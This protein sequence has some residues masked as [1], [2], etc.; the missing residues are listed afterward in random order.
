[1]YSYTIIQW[2]FFFYFYCFFGWCFESTFVSIRKK[3]L[4][5]R[6][7]MR[8]PF[9]PIYGTGAIMMLVVSMPFQGNIFLVYIAGC[10]GAT[11]LEFVTGVLME[12]LFKIRYWDYTNQKINF[13]GYI[14][15]TSSLAW[16][17]LTILMTSVVHNYV[18]A[19]AFLIPYNLL[20]FIT[21][22]L[23]AIIC[24]DFA[25]SFKAAMD[26]RE[27]LVKLEKAKKELV[28]IQKR[29]DVIIAVTGEQLNNRKDG[30]TENIGFKIEDLKHSIEDRLDKAKA[31]SAHKS[32][33][34]SDALKEE[35]KELRFRFRLNIEVRNK[36]GRL[37]NFYHKNILRSNPTMSS[38]KFKDAL[39][40][41]KR[42]LDL[43][44]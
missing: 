19:T 30:F 44:K 2:L 33:D 4:V 16:G 13:R 11:A 28:H 1:M 41:L 39:E 25:L 12:S 7:F 8:G 34:I 18:E 23:T 35:I 31:L 6:G 42:L 27:I 37:R 22:A 24:A 10:I 29:L 36:V 14:C 20:T 26:L 15:L 21:L 5:N 43:E 3:K 17:G 32:N 38:K 9:L 40:E